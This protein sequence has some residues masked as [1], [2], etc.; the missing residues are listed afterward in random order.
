MCELLPP[1]SEN[2]GAPTRLGIQLGRSGIGE[3]LTM[4]GR[5]YDCVPEGPGF[6]P[7][8][9]VEDA[10]AA[11]YPEA[12]QAL[13]REYGQP[14]RGADHPSGRYSASVYL[15]ARLGEL[16]RECLLEQKSGPAAGAWAYNGIYEWWRRKQ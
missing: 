3:E 4:W 16:A 9:E 13:I 15:G 7:Y 1:C 12:L 6:V 2:L 8:G 5:L 11:K 14:W 10:M